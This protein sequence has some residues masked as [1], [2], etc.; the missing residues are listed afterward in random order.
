MIFSQCL[1]VMFK[2][3]RRDIFD[4]KSPGLSIKDAR[5]PNPNP[6]VAADY[7]CV[8]WVDNL[9]DSE[10]NKSYDLSLNEG[11]RVDAFLQ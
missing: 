4:I 7:V 9:Q 11:G 5:Q 3:L 10:R 6:L 8:Y 1:E 2:T